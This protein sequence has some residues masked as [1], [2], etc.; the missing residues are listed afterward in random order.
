MSGSQHHAHH[1]GLLRSIGLYTRRTDTEKVIVDD[2]L[3]LLGMT[4]RADEPFTGLS[5]GDSCWAG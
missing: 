1:L 2:W 3:A 5:F 4:R